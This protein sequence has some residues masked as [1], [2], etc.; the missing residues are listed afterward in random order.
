[1]KHNLVTDFKNLPMYT[2]IGS[3]IITYFTED[4]DTFCGKCVIEED[5]TGK[6]FKG[7]VYEDRYCDECGK[8]LNVYPN[9][10]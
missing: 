3:Y 2:S 1:M 4:S 9:D 8:N 5:L 6:L 7:F 10:D